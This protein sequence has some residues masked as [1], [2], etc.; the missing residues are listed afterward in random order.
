MSEFEVD[1]T[2]M[3]DGNA[4]GYTAACWPS[5]PADATKITPFLLA[6]L[7]ALASSGED[8]NR[9]LIEDRNGSLV[10]L[11]GLGITQVGR[12]ADVGLLRTTV[13]VAGE[14]VSGD[15]QVL[16][17]RMGRVHAR[18]NHCDGH[19]GSCN[20]KCGLGCTRAYQGIGRLCD[21]AVPN[22]RA[23][24]RSRRLIGQVRRG[25]ARIARLSLDD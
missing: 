22:C 2:S 18:I 7:M 16:Q 5:F 25:G 21:V 4:P 23:V 11:C 1:A 8:R 15:Q 24:V 13:G 9:T 20:V 6:Y 10:D 19:A 17:Y 14:V 3:T 12:R